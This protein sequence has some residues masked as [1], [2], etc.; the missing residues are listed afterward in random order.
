MHGDIKRYRKFNKLRVVYS[1]KTK[2]IEYKRNML[3]FIA[4]HKTLKMYLGF[5]TRV[6]I[7]HFCA[8]TYMT[9]TQ[10][11]IQISNSEWNNNL[12]ISCSGRSRKAYCINELDIIYIL[13]EMRQNV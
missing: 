1:F 3:F 5:S 11:T 6:A 7:K 9:Q 12:I 4:E 13:H 2:R 10:H 8:H